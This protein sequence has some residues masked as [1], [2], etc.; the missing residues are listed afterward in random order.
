MSLGD[1]ASPFPA[2]ATSGKT[3]A[4]WRSPPGATLNLGDYFTTDEFESGFQSLGGDLNLSQYTVNLIGTIDNSPADNPI[5]GGTLTLSASTGP[6]SFSGGEIDGRHDHGHCSLV[7]TGAGGTLNGVVVDAAVN[8][9]ASTSLHPARQ[10]ERHGIPRAGLSGTWTNNGTIAATGATLN[11]YDTWTNN[12]TI[13]ADAASTVSLGNS[14]P[15]FPEPATSGKTP[16]PLRSRPVPRSILGDYFT[17]D[18]FESGFQQLGADLNLSQYTVYLI[19][20]LDNSAADNPIT[21]GTL[22]LNAST[23]PLYLGVFTVW[24]ESIEAGVIEQGTITTSG[25]DDLVADDGTLD[26]VTL[27][28]TLDMSGQGIPS[29]VMGG[30]TLD[31]DLYVSGSDAS[32][33][34]LDGST[35]AVGPL[36]Q[37]ATIHLSGDG[38]DCK[39]YAAA[40]GTIGRGITIS[41]ESPDELASTGRST[42]WAPSSRTVPAQLQS[43][44]ASSMMAPSWPATAASLPSRARDLYAN[45]PTHGRALEQQCRRHHHGHPGRDAEPLR[46]LD[47]PGHHHRGL[48]LD[49]ESG[50]SSPASPHSLRSPA[51]SGPT[52]ARSPS[53]RCHGQPGRLLHHRRV[54]EPFPAAWRQPQPSQL[55]G[56]P[57]WHHRQQPRGQ[58]DH[59]RDTGPERL[60]RPPVPGRRDHRPGDDHDPRQRRPGGDQYV[61]H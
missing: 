58:P 48:L 19:G 3:P 11:L 29:H 20:I 33:Y 54:R 39:P 9:P 6:C 47:Q 21:G 50:R 18:E 51:T 28:G 12:G 42:T 27:D 56:Q 60:H 24:L 10:L 30:L 53:P 5:T 32:L 59:R 61:V 49:G 23:G 17:T 57:D 25:T 52:R 16:A 38:A 13:T 45:T 46:H 55:H 1:P 7:A 22:A 8:V 43:P 34:F 14:P 40:D 36:V 31:T 2:P 26:G 41:G 35:V 37:S 44:L 4:C 15:S